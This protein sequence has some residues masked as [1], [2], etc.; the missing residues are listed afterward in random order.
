MPD[1]LLYGSFWLG[2]N[3]ALR[4][5]TRNDANTRTEAEM[6]EGMKFVQHNDPLG[7]LVHVSGAILILCV[8]WSLSHKAFVG[9]LCVMATN[10]VLRAI[11]WWN[12]YRD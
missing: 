9:V 6:S 2:E 1:C 3:C 12:Q 5:P 8:T 4:R 7:I 11:K 10:Y